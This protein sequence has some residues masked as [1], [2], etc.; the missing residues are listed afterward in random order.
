M[1]ETLFECRTIQTRENLKEMTARLYRT[2]LIIHAVALTV[3][4]LAFLIFVIASGR[5]SYL[6]FALILLFAFGGVS[7]YRFESVPTKYS[8]KVYSQSVKLRGEASS[9]VMKADETSIS[10]EN[11]QTRVT[12]VYEYGELTAVRETKNLFLLKTEAKT[13]L[14]I[15]KRNFTTGTPEDFGALLREKTGSAKKR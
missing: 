2:Q 15:D 13:W 11:E 9:G 12:K 3:L 1:Q 6:P 10:H 8:D 7:A 4:A 5:T 14:M